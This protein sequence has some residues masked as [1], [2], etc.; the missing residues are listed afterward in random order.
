[1]MCKKVESELPSGYTRLNYLESTGTQYIDLGV[2]PSEIAKMQL[3][4]DYQITDDFTKNSILLGTYDGS[5]WGFFQIFAYV[6]YDNIGFQF[7][8]KN[9]NT[10]VSKDNVRKNINI[11]LLN[12]TITINNYSPLLLT[13]DTSYAIRT[14][15]YLFCRNTKN[16]AN[17][18]ISARIYSFKIQND[19]VLYRNF[20]PAL[21]T[22]NKPCLYDTV[23]KQ[24]FY[25]E[26]TGEFLYG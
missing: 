5:N 1:M 14:N 26:G 12:K 8:D 24:P 17:L 15:I 16:T 11:N 13:I 4:F 9:T 19:D 2:T 20:V 23:S 22:A 6:N 25:N 21:D 18:F 7:A 10:Y 3:I